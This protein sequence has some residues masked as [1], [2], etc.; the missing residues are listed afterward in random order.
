VAPFAFF[1]GAWLLLSVWL[2]GAL[3][4]SA[5]AAVV[6]AALRAFEAAPQHYDAVITDQTMPGLSGDAFARAML[7]RRP[8]LP[9][10]LCSGYSETTEAGAA[11]RIGIARHLRK[12]LS[13]QELLRALKEFFT[14]NAASVA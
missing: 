8:G 14:A 10:I 11:A 9:I 7:E 6:V 4:G 5:R 13:A 3:I 2:I 1:C 12:P